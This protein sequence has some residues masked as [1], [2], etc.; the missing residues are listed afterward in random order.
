MPTSPWHHIPVFT[1]YLF[2]IK[3]ASILDIGLGNG[4]LG[5]VARDLLDVMYAERYLRTQWQLKLDGIEIFPDY[6]QDHQ[7][8]IYN[9]IYIGNA[10]EILDDLGSYDLIVLGDV[11]EHFERGDG[12]KLLEK[13]FAH[14]SRAVLV[15]V[16]LMYGWKQPAIY[17]NPNERHLASWLPGDLT[18][19]SS[20]YA[21]LFFKAGPYGI[22]LMPKANFE[23]VRRVMTENGKQ[24][25]SAPD[26]YNIRHKLNL[27]AKALASL[28][29]QELA[30][31]FDDPTMQKQVNAPAGQSSTR[32]LAWLGACF[33]NQPVL[34]LE[35][36][37]GF[38]GL[39][40]RHDRQVKITVFSNPL[41]IPVSGPVT[42]LVVATC[43]QEPQTAPILYNHLEKSGF[44][45]W[46]YIE[47]I[48]AN[49]QMIQWWQ[50][51]EK[52]KEDLTDL[53]TQTG[54]GLIYFG[55]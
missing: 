3:P 38:A 42:G 34:L 36:S 11:L 28:D 47:P 22:F 18:P 25:G 15:M 35:T 20:K 8:A 43:A 30:G 31:L 39:A 9:E 4:K 53:G 33:S 19:F 7:R 45:G 16:P 49:D 50:S 2:E 52:P 54:S 55:D 12:W 37:P 41:Q 1:D 17:G 44:R 48:W 13:C 40:L 14:C 23:L 32:L 51:I 6:I 21:I 10:L 24:L 5:F 26:L 27:D 29:M 46:L